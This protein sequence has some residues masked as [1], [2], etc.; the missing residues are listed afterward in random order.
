[1]QMIHLQWV[2]LELS[3]HL[4]MPCYSLPLV[5]NWNRTY[6]SLP[7][8]LLA[9]NC[10]SSLLSLKS[11]TAQRE[12]RGSMILFL[13]L[14]VKMNLQLP[15]NSSIDARRRSCTSWVVLSASSMMMTLCLAV[16]VSETVEANC[17]AWFR[18]VSRN[19]PSSDPLMT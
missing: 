7:M 8:N 17:F 3:R 11:I 12:C 18:T 6:L 2:L 13:K 15:A 19:R 4:L 10:F 14:Q 1:M 16:D 5:D 9:I